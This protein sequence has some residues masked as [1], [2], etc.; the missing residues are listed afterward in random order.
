MSVAFT[1]PA[2]RRS[3]RS[4][5]VAS[6]CASERQNREQASKEKEGRIEETFRAGCVAVAFELFAAPN[7]YPGIIELGI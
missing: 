2:I 6:N 3:C 7:I 1:L 5:Q 4:F